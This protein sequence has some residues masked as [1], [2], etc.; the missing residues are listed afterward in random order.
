MCLNI[1]RYKKLEMLF[2]H[3]ICLLLWEIPIIIWDT[4]IGLMKK[5]KQISIIIF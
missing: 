3:K 5:G 4:N 2:E 1:E